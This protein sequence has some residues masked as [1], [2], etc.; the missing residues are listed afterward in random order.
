VPFAA[1][2]AIFMDAY[3]AL[4]RVRDCRVIYFAARFRRA[5]SSG[6]VAATTS[7]NVLGLSDPIGI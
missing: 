2:V 7:S 3:F 1:A 5:I 4:V 6:S